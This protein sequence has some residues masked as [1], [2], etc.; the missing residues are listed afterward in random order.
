[1]STLTRW[2]LPGKPA[3][4]GCSEGHMWNH[5]RR[6]M[7]LISNICHYHGNGCGVIYTISLP[8]LN[9][10]LSTVLPGLVFNDTSHTNIFI[11]QHLIMCYFLLSSHFL[12]YIP[13][14]SVTGLW[15]LGAG[16]GHLWNSWYR[17]KFTKWCPKR[18]QQVEG[19]ISWRKPWGFQDDGE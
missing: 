3:V 7:R 2:R 6:A 1:M 8:S 15:V 16:E 12:M 18:Y 4:G 17:T 19:L 9:V 13:L 11:L 10:L 14:A 5:Q